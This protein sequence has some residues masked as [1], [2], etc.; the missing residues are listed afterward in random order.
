MS[1]DT[2]MKVELLSQRVIFDDFFRIEEAR[3]R[4]ERFDGTMSPVVRRLNFDRGDAVA[5]VVQDTDTG[6]LLFTNQFK[7][8]TYSGTG[9]WVIEAVAGMIA[10]AESPEAALVRELREELGYDP[11][12][13]EHV[14]TFY[15][16]P[17]GSS[18][19]VWLF[20]ATVDI[21]SRT[22]PGGGLPSEGEDIQIRR[23]S[24]RQAWDAIDVG[25]LHDAKTLIGLLWL[26][27]RLA[28][29]ES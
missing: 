9:G 25:E 3:I 17:G 21:R 12:R 27:S 23:M 1:R 7:Y 10:G 5:A 2:P 29:G 22:G 18:E 20:Y 8:P 13:V 15:V 14:A 6:D 28:R 11:R 24:M 26:R 19:R 4:Y 16:S